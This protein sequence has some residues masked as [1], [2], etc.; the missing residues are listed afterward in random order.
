M[1]RFFKSEVVA[2]HEL[3][4]VHEFANDGDAAKAQVVVE[5]FPVKSCGEFLK[6]IG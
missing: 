2:N 1:G 3:C 5:P 6:E 4:D